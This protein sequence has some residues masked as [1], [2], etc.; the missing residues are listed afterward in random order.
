[1]QKMLYVGVGGFIGACMRYIIS[2]L[3]AKL[4][5][6]AFPYGTLIVNV[7]GGIL[8]GVV[9]QL[10]LTSNAINPNMRLFITSG[11]L[12]SLTVFSTFSY[13]TISLFSDGSYAL[14]LLNIILNIILSFLGI[15][16]GKI[17]V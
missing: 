10:S 13:E 16:I 7:T 9:M 6:S 8:M 15:I 11:I 3:S 14:A 4:F 12:G 5:G 2:M 1:M 17:L